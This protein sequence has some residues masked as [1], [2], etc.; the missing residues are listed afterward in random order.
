M[1]PCPAHCRS[2]SQGV[3]AN[4]VILTI[5]GTRYG[6]VMESVTLDDVDRGLVHALQID[7]RAPFNKIANVLGVS[8]NTVAR[9]C[10]RLRSAGVLRVVGSVNG[11]LLGYTSWTVRVRC[12]PG[13]AGALA[14]A[15]ARR[16]DTFW[17]HVLSGGTEISCNVQARSDSERDVLLMDKLPRNSRVL[18]VSAHSLLGD[19][20]GSGEWAGLEWLTEEQ[21]A[22]LRPALAA[23][24]DG[25]V[26][27]D[28]GDHALLAALSRD[29]RA[30]YAELSTDTGWSESTVKRRLDHF[31][32]A[33]VLVFDVD[34]PPSALG[35]HAEA[36]LWMTV[37]P[38]ALVGTANAIAAH[39]ETTFTAI[40]TGRTN[41]VAAVVCR[42]SRDLHRYLTERI[43]A[44]DDVHSVETA[45]LMRT[46][47]RAGAVLPQ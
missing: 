34:I 29:G 9:R 42:D 5:S 1:V 28:D 18:D 35:Y 43:G 37:R 2:R 47:K 12:T 26:S 4:N 11:S 36:R 8:E 24:D 10:R 31:R 3:T 40:T 15:L 20:S 32:R 7:G 22:R 41:L 44:L 14:A 27:L 30:P 33:G 23:P 39:P 17:V 46:V 16:P 21:V 38:S 25:A 6:E 19:G 13:A 45:P